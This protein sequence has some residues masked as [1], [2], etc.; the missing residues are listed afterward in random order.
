MLCYGYLGGCG[1]VASRLVVAQKNEGS[2]PS[3]HPQEEK[4]AFLGADFLLA[5]S[6]YLAH[7]G[8]FGFINKAL[9]V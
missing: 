6:G 9:L 7:R 3:S 8:Y 4:S 5:E 2:N 1:E